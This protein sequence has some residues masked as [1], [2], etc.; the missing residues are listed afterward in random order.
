MVSVERARRRAPTP[1]AG[2]SRHVRQTLLHWS[3]DRRVQLGL[4]VLAGVLLIGSI[5]LPYW[6]ITLHAPQYPGGLTVSAY[7]H[8]MVGEIREV[9]ELNHYIGMMPLEG[10]AEHERD[11]AVFAIPVVAGLVVAS[12]W[13][14]GR[15]KWLMVL[16]ILIYPFA[17]LGD[18]WIWLY[19]AGH[20]LDPTAAL[21]S[22]I[23]PF[24]PHV[25]GTGKIGQ[26]STEA[27]FAL[28]FYMAFLA[29]LLTL[30][31]TLFARAGHHARP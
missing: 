28:G 23:K 27:R 17:F 11:L 4:L 31:A 25:F 20:S 22:S 13:V 15:W 9:D 24:T 18:L 8:D 3:R 14:H 26:F 21:S 6:D 1:G 30:V 2:K 7:V 12:F 10:A 5:F 16:P 29:A 19:H